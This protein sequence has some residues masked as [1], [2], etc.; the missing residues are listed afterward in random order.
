V[1]ST[2]RQCA[3]G[4]TKRL[5]LFVAAA[6]TILAIPSARGFRASR[7]VEVSTRWMVDQQEFLQLEMFEFKNPKPKP[8]PKDWAPN[9]SGYTIIGVHV[10]DFD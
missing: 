7:G 8:R 6:P 1:C 5:D 10:V 4:I 3:A 2:L 9:H